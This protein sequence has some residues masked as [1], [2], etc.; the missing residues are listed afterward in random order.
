MCCSRNAK[1][2]RGGLVFKAHRLLYHSTLGSNVMKSKI[3]PGADRAQGGYSCA[4][5]GPQLFSVVVLEI[6]TNLAFPR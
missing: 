4:E 5:A 2:F 1:R 3:T 6:L